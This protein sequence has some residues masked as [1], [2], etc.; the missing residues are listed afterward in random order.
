MSILA[1]KDTRVVIQGGQARRERR[2]ADGGILLP[3]QAPA[4]CRS[5][6]VSAGR[7]ENQ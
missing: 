4:Q 3:D 1:N 2:P 7:R 6:C 5:V